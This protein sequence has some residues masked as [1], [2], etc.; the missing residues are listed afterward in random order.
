VKR[1]E[2]LM[3]VGA[4]AAAMAMPG[5]LWAAL[6]G[7]SDDE[8][9]RQIKD[10]VGQMTLDEKLAQMHGEVNLREL[11]RRMREGIREPWPTAD[12]TRLGIPGLRCI[13]GPRGVGTGQPTCFPVGMARGATWDPILEE[14]V[15]SVMGYEA[16]A[17]GANVLLEPCI[18]LLRHPSWGRAQETYG[19]DPYHLGV[20]AANNVQGVQKHLMACAK[21]FAANSIEISRF[22][23]NVV[24]DERT[25]REIYLPH[26]KAC[27]D[28]GVASVM[29]AYNDLNGYLCA[30]NPHL[31]RDILKGDWGFQGFVVSDWS[32]ATEN[33]VAAA[34]GGLDLEMP[35]GEHFGA[36][37]KRAVKAGK[38]S[39]AVINEA[40]TRI[41]RQKLKFIAPDFQA[42]YDRSRVAS[43][44]HAEVALEVA[45]K[46]IVLL[47]NEKSALPLD[48]DQVRKLAVVGGLADV[49]N[50][51]DKGSSNVTPPYV[52]TPLQGI[53]A[54]VGKSL[55]VIYEAGK[56]LGKAKEA[57]KA[58]D[59][60]VIVVGLTSE[61]EGEG[62]YFYGDRSSLNLH[63]QDEKLIQAVV[64]A[65]PR[66]IVVMEGGAAIT[67]EAWQD[68]VPAIL[69]AWYPGMEGGNAIAEL[70]F[71][72]VN[73]SGKLPCVFP[74]SMAD[75][76]RFQP[77]AR[78]VHY[79]SYHG[80]RYQDR[81]GLEPAFPFGFG[82]SYT[83]YQYSNLRLDQKTIGKSG[84]LTMQVDVTN[85]GER[86]GEEVVQLYV[87]YHGSKVDRPVK[88][89]KGFGR[90]ALQPGE[91]KTVTL[92]LRAQDLAY[93]NMN[94]NAWEVEEIEYLVS[95]GP[96]SRA[97]DLQLRETFRIAGA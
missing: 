88:E 18:N 23:V 8:I 59:A 71:G 25:L 28:A 90:V 32:Q 80:Y 86:A 34:K 1:R 24:M 66:C 85:T 46:G 40:V 75:L 60:V 14:Q 64:E 72:E 81:K 69:M 52:I 70:L 16:R 48:R 2:F 93:Y 19:E 6:S 63:K 13:D 92:E 4:G 56:D 7:L 58:A 22:Y 30:E 3:T 84:K 65:N 45:R 79:D 47:K 68:Q 49:G 9:E 82:L 91:T 41:L 53:Q 29:S 21:H 87:G 26:F 20:M 61:D 5:A 50:I 94:R 96:S 27:V 36:S 44:E 37:L 39:E 67:V 35:T 83:T 74:K 73:P 97:E 31:L 42:G 12:N 89:L 62:G 57:A 95:V 54:K 77:R 10:L 76:P 55:E 43:R 11:A 17:L 33:A 15:G 78:K 38:V 51:G